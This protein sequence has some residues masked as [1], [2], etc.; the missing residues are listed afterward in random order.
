MECRGSFPLLHLLPGVQGQQRRLVVR[1]R[2][3]A[4]TGNLPL[5]CDTISAV[6]VGSLAARDKLQTPLD[7]YQEDDL[8]R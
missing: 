1:V 4:N 6:S 3:A 8:T 5:V 2:S 7:S